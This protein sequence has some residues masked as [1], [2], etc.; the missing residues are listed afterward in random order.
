MTMPEYDEE[1]DCALCKQL[2]ERG[3]PT[4]LK[5]KGSASVRSQRDF[6]EHMATLFQTIDTAVYSAQ[7]LCDNKGHRGS[8]CLNKDEP[9]CSFRS[10]WI[11]SI[12]ICK[13]HSIRM[14]LGEH[15]EQ[16]DIPQVELK[17]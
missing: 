12:S 16:H 8:V 4:K 7:I 11:G 15:F 13:L 17:E 5:A 10:E 9:V 3:I 1:C 6:I 14:L 2:R